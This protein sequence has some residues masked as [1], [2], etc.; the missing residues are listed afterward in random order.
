MRVL[1]NHQQQCK[2]LM[3]RGIGGWRGVSVL[4]VGAIGSGLGVAVD[5]GRAEILEGTV[6]RFGM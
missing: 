3:A 2:S 4:P 6:S 5:G 1:E